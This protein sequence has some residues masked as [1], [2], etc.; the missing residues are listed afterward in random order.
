[1]FPVIDLPRV[2]VLAEQGDEL[3]YEIEMSDGTKKAILIP[4]EE[5]ECGPMTV[6]G[7]GALTVTR[8][9]AERQGLV[10]PRRRG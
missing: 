10:G 9:W 5:I 4:K 3:L 8:G 7:T 6:G 2:R 1:M